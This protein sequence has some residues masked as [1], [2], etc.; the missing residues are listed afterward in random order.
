[1]CYFACDVLFVLYWLILCVLRNGLAAPVIIRQALKPVG[2]FYHN[3]I[4]PPK[5][6]ETGEVDRVCMLAIGLG[7]TN[8]VT[9][10]SQPR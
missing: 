1:M 2:I 3:L 4:R 6:Q 5:M 10:Q 7:G 8:E 9:D